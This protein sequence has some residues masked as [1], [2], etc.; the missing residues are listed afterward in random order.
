MA[1][2][3]ALFALQHRTTQSH[4]IP[5]AYM[6]SRFLRATHMRHGTPGDHDGF[7]DDPAGMSTAAQNPA[8]RAEQE[9]A[10]RD[11]SGS[12]V[13]SPS[14]LARALT[15]ELARTM[16]LGWQGPDFGLETAP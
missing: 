7:V 2:Y 6:H 9:L 3:G 16:A 10:N 4:K 11:L 5:K 8:A 1:P 12:V 14:A 13:R 15:V